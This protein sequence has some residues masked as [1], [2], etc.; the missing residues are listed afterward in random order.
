MKKK[1]SVLPVKQVQSLIIPEEIQ[2]TQLT[3]QQLQIS[4]LFWEWP[5][6]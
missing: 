3:P 2:A 5:F 1:E 6:L 4:A